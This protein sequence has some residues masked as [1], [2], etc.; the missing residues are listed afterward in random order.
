MLTADNLAK[1]NLKRRGSKYNSTIDAVLVKGSSLK[2][3]L[4]DD[5]TLRYFHAGINKD[6]Y[7]NSSHAK[8]QLEAF[9]DCITILYPHFDI[10]YLY[11][12]SSGHTKLRPDGLSANNMNIVPGGAVSSM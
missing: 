5:P 4:N 12:Q 10:T 6:R 9:T 8:V 2:A 3:D 1:I 7:W 11:D